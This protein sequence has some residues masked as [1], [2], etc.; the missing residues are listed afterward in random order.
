MRWIIQ[1]VYSKVVEKKMAEV[2]DGYE[3]GMGCVHTHKKKEYAQCIMT[4]CL[5][6]A[7]KYPSSVKVHHMEF[8][9]PYGS[10]W[11]RIV[12]YHANNALHI[13]AIMSRIV[14]CQE[15]YTVCV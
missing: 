7:I 12:P 13:R 3:F 5:I 1:L 6:T 10:E 4:Q 15:L 14:C 8:N 9:G 2:S 11:S